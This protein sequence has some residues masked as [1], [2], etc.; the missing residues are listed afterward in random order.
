[1]PGRSDAGFPVL[2]AG[3]MRARRVD[4]GYVKMLSTAVLAV[5]AVMLRSTSAL[6]TAS[7]SIN[8]IQHDADWQQQIDSFVAGLLRYRIS[9]NSFISHY[10]FLC[11]RETRMRVESVI[12]D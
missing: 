4:V 7:N 10:L 11:L 9:L 1:M 3:G 8:A 12:I 2:Q 6:S 5:A